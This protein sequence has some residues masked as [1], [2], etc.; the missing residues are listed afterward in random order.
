[1]GSRS[2][3]DLFCILLEL[4]IIIELVIGHVTKVKV[5]SCLPTE[6]LIAESMGFGNIPLM[7][8]ICLDSSWFLSQKT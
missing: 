6:V 5:A 8:V 7:N 3:F 1:M 4:H 2:V